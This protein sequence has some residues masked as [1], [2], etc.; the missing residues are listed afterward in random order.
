MDFEKYQQWA[1]HRG[2]GHE[3]TVQALADYWQEIVAEM[4]QT[5]SQEMG[6]QTFG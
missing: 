1:E 6:G 3:Q 5:D 2:G 4:E